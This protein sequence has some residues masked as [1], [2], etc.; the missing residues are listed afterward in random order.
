[1][2]GL[3][4]KWSGKKSG[5]ITSENDKLELFYERSQN[6]IESN[7]RESVKKETQTFYSSEKKVETQEKPNCETSSE[8]KT[9]SKDFVNEYVK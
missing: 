3:L 9:A 7:P 4:N 1:M 2:E 8:E 5:K 6:T